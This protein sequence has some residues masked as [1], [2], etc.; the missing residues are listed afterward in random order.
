MSDPYEPT[1]PDEPALTTADLAGASTAAPAEARSFDDEAVPRPTQTQ[2]EAAPLFPSEEASAFRARWDG[3]QAGFV[4]EPRQAVEQADSLV[5]GAM[6]RLAETF[7]KERANLEGQW[8]RGDDVS[9]ED[10]RLALQRY[11]SFFGR[12]LSM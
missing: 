9:T 2:H 6:K 5:A 3:I 4:D 8:D 10:L 1:R 12:L 7:A 11:R